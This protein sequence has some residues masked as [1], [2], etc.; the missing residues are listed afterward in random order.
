MLALNASADR[1]AALPALRRLAQDG[2]AFV[3]RFAILALKTLRDVEAIPVLKAIAIDDDAPPEGIVAKVYALDA[4]VALG[5]NSLLREGAALLPEAE[6]DPVLGRVLQQFVTDALLTLKKD[7]IRIWFDDPRPGVK[8]SALLALMDFELAES[9]LGSDYE[10]VRLSAALVLLSARHP[11]ALDQIAA[12]DWPSVRSRELLVISIDALLS[13]NP[14]TPTPEWVLALASRALSDPQSTGSAIASSISILDRFGGHAALQ[15]ALSE[16]SPMVRLAA[17][18]S[19]RL[20]LPLSVLRASLKSDQS[21]IRLASLSSLAIWVNTQAT[22]DEATEAA[23]FI[24]D[25][26]VRTLSEARYKASVLFRSQVVNPTQEAIDAALRLAHSENPL[27]REAAASLLSI[28]SDS[29]RAASLLIQMMT[30][31]RRPI[32]ERA[33]LSVLLTSTTPSWRGPAPAELFPSPSMFPLVRIY[34]AIA[35]AKTGV[36][37]ALDELQNELK[38]ASSRTRRAALTAMTRVGLRLPSL[39]PGTSTDPDPAVRALS[40]AVLGDSSDLSAVL[41]LRDDVNLWVRAIAL[42]TIKKSGDLD[43]TAPLVETLKA[44]SNQPG[45][46]AHLAGTAATSESEIALVTI[47][48]TRQAIDEGTIGS[49]LDESELAQS[50]ELVAF[51]RSGLAAHVWMELQAQTDV[52]L[53]TE[54]VRSLSRCEAKAA[55]AILAVFLGGD[56]AP[57]S[58]VASASR[59]SYSTLIGFTATGLDLNFHLKRGRAYLT[60]NDILLAGP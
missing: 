27:E 23:D 16:G 34:M 58:D 3:A 42:A 43:A 17:L 15:K 10:T 29:H 26:E 19:S 24:R 40:V 48:A 31:T 36:I 55:L 45:F 20:G 60:E 13:A 47:M 4:L 59:N 52:R 2:D 54:L 49:A 7:E 14:A 5:D 6:K 22:P 25:L 35:A 8:A 30:E 53:R 28:S 33:A 9:A 1:A 41:P 37:G 32:A 46:A 38:S 44:L 57:T 51:G 21:D 50:R 11:S 12:L 39:A 18:S 56:T